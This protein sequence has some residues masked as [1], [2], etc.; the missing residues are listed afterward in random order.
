MTQPFIP[1]PNPGG[2]TRRVV[3]DALRDTITSLRIPG[4]VLIYRSLPPEWQFEEAVPMGARFAAAIAITVGRVVHIRRANT[5]PTDPGGKVANHECRLVIEHRGFGVEPSDW[6]DAEDDHD[7]IIGAL[8]DA[9]AA[10]GRD[11]GRPDVILQA[12]DWPDESLSYDTGDPE[13]VNGVRQQVT[14]MDFITSIYMQRQ[15]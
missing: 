14:T 8:I 10:A 11:L 6:E 15:P 13:N 9:L 2:T 4:V 12:A 1:L 3:R 5:G 7:R